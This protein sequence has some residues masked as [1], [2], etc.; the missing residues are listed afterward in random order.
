M[1][2]AVVSVER[3]E[4]LKARALARV[5]ELSAEIIALADDIHAHPELGYQ[6]RRTVGLVRDLLARHGIESEVG[7]GGLETALRARVGRGDGARVAI[8]A[9][10]DALPGLGH[11]C[12][13]NAIC[14]SAVGAT[15]ALA[16]LRNDLPGEALLLGCPAEESAVDNAGGKIHLLAAGLFEGVDAAIMVHPNDR[17]DGALHTSLAARGVQFEFRGKPAHAAAAPHEGINALDAMILLFQGIGLLRQQAR[18]DC[19]IH[20]IITHG[21]DAPNII[22]AY[23]AARFR[24]RAAD[25]ATMQDLYAR[26]VAVAEGAARATGATL[27]YR[28]FAPPYED[29]VPNVILT[30]QVRAAFAAVGRPL[31]TESRGGMGST[32]FGNVSRR[33]PAYC[34]YVRIADEGIQPHTVEFADAAR[35][36][37]AHAMILDS[38]KAMALTTIEL[39]ARPDLLAAAQA[40]FQ[41]RLKGG[42]R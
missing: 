32:D 3:W 41:T 18:A 25:L 33:I 19:R 16:A 5:D 23:T 12:G 37:A 13:H 42:A 36:P 20:G 11:A 17:D 40:E 34:P 28:D 26:V 31:A 14:M 7:V 38:A 15:L 29:Q 21:G 39:L 1:S 9:E 35:T 6:E 27:S 22:P 10:Y 2:A 4:A 24:V 8:L 30:E